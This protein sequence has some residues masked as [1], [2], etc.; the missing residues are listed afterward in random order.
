M[1]DQP[2]AAIAPPPPSHG[3]GW[4][5][6][7]FIFFIALALV[8]H[9]ALIF[10]FGTKKQ[11]V[12]RALGEVPHLQLADKADEFIALSDPTLFARPN[13]HDMVTAF[14]RR[15]PIPPAPDFNWTEAPRYLP[16]A[17]EKFGAV[18]REFMTRPPAGG[19]SAGF[20][21]RPQIDRARRGAQ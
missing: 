1:N 7:K 11:I 3:E 12:P 21:A 15:P 4:P 2:A 10:I 16:P 18:F 5:R 20:Q 13:A 8:L 9:L 14:W 19:N 6:N 17:P